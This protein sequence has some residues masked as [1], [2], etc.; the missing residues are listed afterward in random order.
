MS[1][2]L[3]IVFNQPVLP[4]TPCYQGLFVS[5]WAM[6]TCGLLAAYASQRIFVFAIP[7]IMNLQMVILSILQYTVLRQI[8][9]GHRNWEELVG[10]AL[11]ITGNISHISRGGGERHKKKRKKEGSVDIDMLMRILNFS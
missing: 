9:T 1:V 7:V 11:I 5:C 3:K 8:H 4:T 6:A 10:M 2:G